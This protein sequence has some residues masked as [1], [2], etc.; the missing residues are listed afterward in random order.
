M[1][2]KNFTR[3]VKI[4][5]IL[6]III[7]ILALFPLIV[8]GILSGIIIN[9]NN[10]Q[11]FIEKGNLLCEIAETNITTR[12]SQYESML[13]SISTK[14]DFDD[15][16][17]ISSGLLEDMKLI[18]SS[19]NQ[20][21][22]VYFASEDGR[23][24]QTLNVDLPDGY[25]HKEKD[26]YIECSNN[27]D[28]VRVEQPYEDTLTSEMVTTV[29]RGVK[30]NGKVYGVIA[31]DV[32]LNDLSEILS[33]IKYGQNS[34]FIIADPSNSMVV[35]S[36][37]ESKIGQTEPEEYTIWDEVKNNTNGR[38][39]LKYKNNNYEVVYTTSSINN[40]KIILQEPSDEFNQ[41]MNK[42][43]ISNILIIVVLAAIAG[44]VGWYITKILSNSIIE[45][46]E[47]IE[48][49]AKGKFTDKLDKT[50][51]IYEFAILIESF[52]RM[53]DD[54]GKLM[55]S[56]DNSIDDVNKSSNEA[57]EVSKQITD[58]IEQVAETISQISQGN[59]QCSENLE[60]ITTEINDLSTSMNNID[61]QTK[62]AKELSKEADKLS[63]YGTKMI[64]IIKE[65]SSSTKEN[66][67][68]VKKVVYDVAD[69]I[70]NISEMNATISN[71]TSQTNLLAL[72]AAIEAARAGE[73]GK[74]FA[75]VA[76][77]IRKLAEET[78]Y[79]SCESR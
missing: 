40:W 73:S 52:N 72:N 5:T 79:R 69:S 62:G 24:I 8:S 53:I 42:I 28:K 45:V 20:I 49:A 31:M 32:K 48:V 23:F 70:K 12:I 1:E 22:N 44:L 16:Q 26:W 78:C 50:S 25:N 59:V 17:Y 29:Y 65:K 76:E 11:S 54:I 37:D 56:V 41:S 51:K 66:S 39:H 30:A 18:Q 19:D 34:Q 33:K 35:F 61:K 15:E 43:F 14:R 4:K 2:R 77:E 10:E 27:P 47:H 21:V 36:G 55:G 74:G 75:V 58:S 68:E 60:E 9:R 71:I 63:T 7:L 3:T 6:M 64:D 13:M 38:T 57:F 46:K 67:E